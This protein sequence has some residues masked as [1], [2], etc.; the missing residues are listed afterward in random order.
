M[1]DYLN[2]S[3][4]LPNEPNSSIFSLTTRLIPSA[5]GANNLRGSKPLPTKSLPSKMYCLVASWKAN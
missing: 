1:E 5:P 3:A 4:A 2:Y